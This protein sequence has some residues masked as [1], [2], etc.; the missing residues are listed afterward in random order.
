MGPGNK[1]IL[2]GTS[3]S[4]RKPEPKKIILMFNAPRPRGFRVL[5][6]GFRGFRESRVR[7]VF[8]GF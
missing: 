1:Y 4:N 7:R 3:S 6:L 8:N 2:L 5:G